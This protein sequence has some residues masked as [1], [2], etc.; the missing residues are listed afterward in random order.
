MKDAH[1]IIIRPVVTEKSSAMME[2]RK[3]VFQVRRDATKTDI[4]RAIEQKFRVKVAKVNT[5]TVP[6]KARR[7]GRFVGRTPSWKKAIVT[8]APGH[9]IN[10]FE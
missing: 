4:K 8:L 5:L 10:I 9:S 6:G 7:M 2:Q 3:Y 1:D